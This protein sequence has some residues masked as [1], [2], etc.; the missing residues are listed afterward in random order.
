M[1]ADVVMIQV[2]TQVTPIDLSSSD[3]IQVARGSVVTDSEGT[4]QATLMF[5]QGIQATMT[6]PDGTTQPL[7]N[8]IHVR[9]TEYTVGEN[10]PQSHACRTALSKRLYI[11]CRVSVDEATGATDV[12]FDRPVYTYVENFLNF[13]VG[14]IVPVGY[15]NRSLGQ[16]IPSENG[17]IIK[18]LV[19]QVAWLNLMLMEATRQPMRRSLLLSIS[20]TLRGRN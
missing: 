2:D 17:I 19:S 20:P 10:G 15:Y 4:R 1:A 9:A 13:P 18:I 7:T 3:P 5:P 12:R 8:S 14:G 11:R 6:L 16:W